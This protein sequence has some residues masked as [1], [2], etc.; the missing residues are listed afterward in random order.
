MTQRFRPIRQT[1]LRQTT[2]ALTWLH[3]LHQQARSRAHSE[4]DHGANVIETIMIVA[5]FA[6][7]AGALVLAVKGKVQGW[8]DQIP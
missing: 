6:A 8:I 7:I 3:D 2:R 4:P 1:L 5:G